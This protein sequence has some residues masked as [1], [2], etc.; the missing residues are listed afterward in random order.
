MM[1][2][3][4]MHTRYYSAARWMAGDHVSDDFIETES[5]NLMKMPSI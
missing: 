3:Q 5:S 1:C 2:A 4:F